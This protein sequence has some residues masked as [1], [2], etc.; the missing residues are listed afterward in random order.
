MGRCRSEH[1]PADIRVAPLHGTWSST[2]VATVLTRRPGE[3]T[4][5]AH[6]A[7]ARAPPAQGFEPRTVR[8]P[9]S[10]C[11]GLLPALLSNAPHI[12]RSLVRWAYIFSRALDP[13]EGRA[14]A[15]ASGEIQAT[16][17]HTLGWHTRVPPGSHH[18]CRPFLLGPVAHHTSSGTTVP[19][20]VQGHPGRLPGP[21]RRVGSLGCRGR[22]FTCAARRCACARPGRRLGCRGCSLRRSRA[23]PGSLGRARRSRGPGW[24]LPM[25]DNKSDHHEHAH[26]TQHAQKRVPL[27]GRPWR[28]GRYVSAHD[29]KISPDEWPRYL[30][31]SVPAAAG[32]DQHRRPSAGL[33]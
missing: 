3:W 17:R 1:R 7:S 22:L 13:S 23:L 8:I 19:V 5:G 18:H 6:S 12:Q 28:P 4:G 30:T 26:H 33:S 29:S 27:P 21:A 16:K 10:T 2:S 24:R 32:I 31:S 20:M 25:K 15:R 14:G 9:D 11:D